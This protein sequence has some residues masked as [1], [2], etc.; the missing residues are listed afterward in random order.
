M[1]YLDQ[2]L[3]TFT[4]L[5]CPG[6]GMQNSDEASPSRDHFGRSRSFSETAHNS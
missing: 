4:I 6:T 5:H 3:H 2:I 1:V